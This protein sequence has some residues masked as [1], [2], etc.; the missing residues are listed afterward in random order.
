MAF[1]ADLHIHSKFSRATARNLDLENIYQA[2]Q[3]KGITVVGTGDFTHPAWV[4]EMES[5]LEP[6]EPGL[7]ALKKSLADDID[8]TVPVSCKNPVRFMLQV[9]ISN[10]YKKSG[11]VRKN[12]N[13]IY[14]PDLASVKKFNARLD[15][16]GNITSDGRPI[17]GLDARDLLEIML[18]VNDQGFLVPAHIW[19]PWFSMFGS[20][21]GFDHIKECFGDL[22]PHIFAVETGL[23]SDP[24]MNWRVADLDHVRLMSNSDAHS[25]GYLGRNAC[26]FSTK[27]DYFAMKQSLQTLDLEGYQGTLDMY[28]DQGKYHFDGHR[29]CGVSLDPE[30]TAR[31]NKIC[32]VC[33]RPLTLGVLHRVRELA[34]RPFGYVP[35][36]RHGYTSIIPLAD[37]LS[38]IFQVGP[39]TKKVARYY[40][41]A[42]QALGPELEILTRC[43]GDRIRSA[44]VPLL[45]E[46]VER[47]RSG[48][49]HVSPGYDG[50]YGKVRVFAPDELAR[51]KGERQL[52]M[53][54]KGTPIEQI[55]AF[56]APQDPSGNDSDGHTAA[57]TVSGPAPSASRTVKQVD[58]GIL[59]GLNDA[60]HRA[61]TSTAAA[62]LITAGPGTGKTRT[63]TARIARLLKEKQVSSD[64]IL[65]L[66]FTNRAAKEIQTR[67][68]SV[69]PGKGHRVT[70]ATFHGFCL[71][72][73]KE[74][75]ALTCR[76]L[77]DDARI[78]CIRNA[79]AR[80]T[81]KRTGLARPAD[82]MDLQISLCKQ[83]LL[84]PE[85]DLSGAGPDPGLLKQ[86]YAAYQK[87]LQAAGGMDF[88]DLIMRFYHLITR[89]ETV[90]NRVQSRFAH[91]FV[92]EYQDLNVGQYELVRELARHS[93]LF[94]IGDP[95]QSIY[96][97]RGSDHRFFH[98]FADDYPGCE[99]I[100]LTK[101]YRSTQTILDAS[102]QMI[103]KFGPD[104]NTRRIY[105]QVNGTKKV[106]IRETATETAEAV[107]VGKMIEHAMGGMSLD[108]ITIQKDDPGRDADRGFS[109]F[110]VLYRTRRQGEV[111]AEVFQKHG[112]PFQTADKKAGFD[113]A[114][115]Q[116]LLSCL[117]LLTRRA[118]DRDVDRLST[119]LQARMSL[120]TGPIQPERIL[121]PVW[122][123][124]RDQPGHVWLDAL[125]R[126]LK[127]EKA[128]S[129]DPVAA[130]AYARIQTLA[131][132]FDDPEEFMDRLALDRD[133]DLLAGG[134]EKV[135]L[136]TMHAAKGLEFPVVF[137][138]GCEQGMIPFARNGSAC[139]NPSEERRLFYVAMTR[140]KDLLCLTY[141]RKRRMFGVRRDMQP[142]MFIKDIETR[143]I[144]QEV[145]RRTVPI[146]KQPIQ[147]ELF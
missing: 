9:E 59:E 127:I 80:V 19:T 51:F 121:G 49:V 141:A 137:V 72:M 147:L 39:K 74:Y 109:D 24:P 58:P 69:S 104:R 124:V 66:T 92:D 132:A 108:A 97:F 43:D 21:S 55:D 68:Q 36:T 119:H 17:L 41:K 37:I 131:R 98:Q 11:R 57:G 7:F 71:S 20:K 61:V 6:A 50:E 135:S 1:F 60:Q 90:R 27:L 81:G 46:A 54:L 62:I 15:A 23:S 12:H 105:S 103:S 100:V 118:G 4:A 91:V 89:S 14:F 76:I 34:D 64:R 120:E 2:A 79:L 96:G 101:N 25:P 111:F 65:A 85:D 77:E 138:T 86:V 140:A 31:L 8:A 139:E 38:D 88:E 84:T 146:Q 44:G 5:K 93:Q 142:S 112:I 143:L 73:L 3:V 22:A 114:Q 126:F 63:L 83:R 35:E 33:G 18:E 145:Q 47:M 115:I 67:I 70:A 16:I 113:R 133:S 117:R 40:D 116:L 125:T 128:V 78:D 107:A 56:P 82:E 42:V 26:V 29:K 87:E 94:V 110:A 102:F 10:I 123:P 28:P 45:A 144:E 134:V 99:Q 75:D 52:K 106:I 136:L 13:I 53:T 48:R 30:E 122:E 95:D 130:A 32:P 129:R